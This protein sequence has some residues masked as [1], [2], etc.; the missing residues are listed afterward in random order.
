MSARVSVI[1]PV[2]DAAS[3]LRSA[4]TSIQR[5]IGSDEETLTVDDA[6]KDETSAILPR[7]I[8]AGQRI[9]LQTN[10]KNLGVAVSLNLALDAARGRYIAHMDAH[11]ISTVDHI[12]RQ[13]QLLDTNPDIDLH[14]V[15]DATFTGKA[16]IEIWGDGERTH[17]LMCIHDCIRHDFEGHPFQAQI[18][19]ELARRGYELEHEFCADYIRGKGTLARRLYDSHTLTFH[20][21]TTNPPFVNC[22]LAGRA[23]YER[24]YAA[25]LKGHLT[26]HRPN[27][28]KT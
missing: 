13:V 18:S 22:G 6:N 28:T 8:D 16:E 1:L 17:S 26:Q 20:P 2:H 21:Q 4:I 5:S 9:R 25:T 10:S 3:T 27:V 15:I 14:K 12:P 7:L 19:R 24:A 23:R 11:D